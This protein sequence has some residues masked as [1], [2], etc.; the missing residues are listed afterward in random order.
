VFNKFR[1]SLLR[2]FKCTVNYIA[3]LEFHKSGIPHLHVLIDRFIAQRWISEA[4][5]ALGG[6][7][8]VD[9]RFVDVHRISHYLAKYLTK[10]LLMSA[11]AAFASR[12]YVA[13]YSLA[14]KDCER[15]NLA[16]G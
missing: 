14:R 4:W 15:H 1:V 12:H 7:G 8:I 2:K 5:S 13:L 11:A 9:I 3:I 16:N 6:G 10:E